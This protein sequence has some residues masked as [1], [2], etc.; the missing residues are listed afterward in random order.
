M[1]LSAISK[2]A[3]EKGQSFDFRTTQK[4]SMLKIFFHDIIVESAPIKI[5]M[6]LLDSDEKR[7]TKK[8]SPHTSC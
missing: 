2:A 7:Y 5:Q 4:K 6:Y 8:M 3:R 1:R